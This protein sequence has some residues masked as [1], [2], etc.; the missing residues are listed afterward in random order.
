MSKF[1]I[2]EVCAVVH[3]SLTQMLMLILKT[4]VMMLVRN[5]R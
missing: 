2:E 5:W 3:Y 4:T 1:T